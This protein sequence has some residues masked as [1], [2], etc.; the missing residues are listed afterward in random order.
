MLQEE[1]VG[2][3]TK[4]VTQVEV[5]AVNRASKKGVDSPLAELIGRES[6]KAPTNIANKKLNNMKC[7]VDI[8]NRCFFILS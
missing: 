3:T 7:V 2:T 1:T 4:P 8:E 5:V 6:N